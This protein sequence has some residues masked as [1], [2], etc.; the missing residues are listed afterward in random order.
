MTKKETFEMMLNHFNGEVEID[1][2][3][4]EELGAIVETKRTL[5]LLSLRLVLRRL[6]QMTLTT[7]LPPRSLLP[8]LTVM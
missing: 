8:S 1:E 4:E 2:M 3:T 6:W 5:K 7:C